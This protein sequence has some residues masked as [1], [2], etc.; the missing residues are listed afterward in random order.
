MSKIGIGVITCNRQS[1]YEK[2]IAS[3]AEC[4]L[5][6]IVTIS[7]GDPYTLDKTHGDFIQHDTNKGVGV[8]KNDALRFLLEKDCEHIFLIEDDIFIMHTD[9]CKM[10]VDA[11]KESGIWHMMFGYHGPA[12]KTKEGK[13]PH[14]KM[15][16]QYP[17]GLKLAFNHHCVGAF[18]YY[19]K[20]ILDHI[21]LMDETY[22]NAWEHVDHSLQIV[23]AGLLPGYWWW[24]DLANSYDLL[25]E[26][27]CSEENS[28]IRWADAEQKIP[29]QDWEDNIYAGAM[30]FEK[31]HGYFP[32][33]IPDT[34][35]NEIARRL[36]V[37]RERYSRCE[38]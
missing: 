27:A 26:Q 17:S 24:P 11:A 7:D 9:V 20:N 16:M 6:E 14:P 8:S 36:D 10:Y 13:Q 25:S 38:V 33:N 34:D 30:H 28:V 32:G 23:K 29:K 12:N 21:G 37:I 5:D 15:V 35:E 3:I 19:H 1:F 2:C 4:D 31:K 22:K 18:C